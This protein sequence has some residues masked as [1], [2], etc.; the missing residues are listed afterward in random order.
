MK[1]LDKL[2]YS[3]G[4]ATQLSPSEELVQRTQAK[5]RRRQSPRLLLAA[6]A[7][8]GLPL[9]YAPLAVLIAVPLPLPQLLL[10]ICAAASFYNAL[11][12]VMWLNRAQLS[13]IAKEVC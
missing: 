3:F 1:D 10:S 13:K 11:I 4:K 12:I 9:L 5:V 6:A 2:L 8:L 7:I